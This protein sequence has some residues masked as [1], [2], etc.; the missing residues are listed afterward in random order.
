[1]VIGFPPQQLGFGPGQVGFVVD[2]MAVMQVFSNYFGFPRQF[3]FRQLPHI[4]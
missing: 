4:H 2:Q 1:L 3:E